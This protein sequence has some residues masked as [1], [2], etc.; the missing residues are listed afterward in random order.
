[1]K[2]RIHAAACLLLCALASSFAI[3]ADGKQPNIVIIKSINTFMNRLA[4]LL[5]K[6]MS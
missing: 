4:K 6:Q 2:Y 5:K 3:A 1:M